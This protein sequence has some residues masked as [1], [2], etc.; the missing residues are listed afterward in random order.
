MR[1]QK[2]CGRKAHKDK[3]FCYQ[4]L[5]RMSTRQRDKRSQDTDRHRGRG[6]GPHRVRSWEDNVAKKKKPEPKKP[7]L[8]D[9]EKALPYPWAGW[10]ASS[11]AY[12]IPLPYANMTDSTTCTP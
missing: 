10:S 3:R 7:P 2:S 9:Q 6:R 5:D 8:T 12:R 4:C 1:C 11:S